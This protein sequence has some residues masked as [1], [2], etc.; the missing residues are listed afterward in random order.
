MCNTVGAQY[1]VNAIH[2][3]SGQTVIEMSHTS[4]TGSAF[5]VVGLLDTRGTVT[6]A[7]GGDVKPCGHLSVRTSFCPSVCLLVLCA[8]SDRIVSYHILRLRLPWNTNKKEI[9]RCW[10]SKPLVSVACGHPKWTKRQRSRRLCLIL[11]SAA[12]YRFATPYIS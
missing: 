2:A 6:V 7:L 1:V 9:S 8:V 10:K 11:P 12:T 5:V 3:A 4:V